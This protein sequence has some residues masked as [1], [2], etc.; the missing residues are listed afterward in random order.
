MWKS[1][2]NVYFLY[3]V[4]GYDAVYFASLREEHDVWLF[5]FWWLWSVVC[6][7]VWVGRIPWRREGLPTRGSGLE[8]PMGCMESG[9]TERLA[10]VVLSSAAVNFPYPSFIQ[11]CQQP[12][13]T[14]ALIHC[15]IRGCKTDFQILS[16][17]LHLLS[18]I[19][20]ERRIFSKAEWGVAV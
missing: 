14:I 1:T 4:L 12:L 2:C 11:E 20:L 6:G 10:L 7:G 9:T 3:I 15:F 13:M 17:L 18:V 8:N 5:H 19:L 16:N